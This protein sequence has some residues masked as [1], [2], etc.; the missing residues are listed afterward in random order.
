MVGIVRRI[1]KR[2]PIDVADGLWIP[3]EVALVDRG[4]RPPR[5][6]LKFARPGCND[7]VCRANPDQGEK[8]GAI[9]GTIK[10]CFGQAANDPIECV[11]KFSAQK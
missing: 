9:G 4:D 7:T 1:N 11:K 5:W 6:M 10:M 3:V 2:F 8:A